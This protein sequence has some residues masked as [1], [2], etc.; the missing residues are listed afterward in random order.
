MKFEWIQ[1]RPEG[2][3][4][5]LLRFRSLGYQRWGRLQTRIETIEDS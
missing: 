1:K 2:A 4:T 3:G 5:N